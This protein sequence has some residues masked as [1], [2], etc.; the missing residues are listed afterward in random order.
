M[1]SD[2]RISKME[3]VIFNQESAIAGLTGKI[4]TLVQTLLR[5]KSDR[6]SDS[7]RDYKDF[8]HLPKTP[9]NRNNDRRSTLLN[10]QN[11]NRNEQ[12]ITMVAAQTPFRT[13]T[14]ITKPDY[15]LWSSLAR[16]LTIWQM[17]PGNNVTYTHMYAHIYLSLSLSLSLSTHHYL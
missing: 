8:S 2:E 16:E 15:T 5:E 9:L 11:A 6:D 3:E 7:D 17:T 12:S 1:S 10:D 14:K 4:E 13:S